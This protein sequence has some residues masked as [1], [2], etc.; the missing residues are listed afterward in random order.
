[1]ISIGPDAW[2]RFHPEAIKRLD[3]VGRWLNVNGEAIFATRPYREY[4]EGDVYFTRTKDNQYVYAIS[5]Q[6]PMERITLK[7][8]RA[9][10]GSEISLLGDG[11]PLPWQQKEDGLVIEIPARLQPKESRPCEQAYVFKIR[12]GSTTE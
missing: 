5:M 9:H 6:W 12:Q 1:M 3:H 7:C 8:V 4:R 11:Q 2:G 10:P